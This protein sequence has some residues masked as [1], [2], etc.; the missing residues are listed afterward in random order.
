MALSAMETGAELARRNGITTGPDVARLPSQ[1]PDDATPIER[2]VWSKEHEPTVTLYVVHGRGHV[3][4]QPAFRFPRMLGR[5][6]G[7]LNAPAEAVTFF[8]LGRAAAQTASGSGCQG[9][10]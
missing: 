9:D 6:T 1:N 4:P 10:C 5:M 3:V 8:R 2:L 7:N